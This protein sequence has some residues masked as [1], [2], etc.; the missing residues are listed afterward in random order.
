MS[1]HDR[2]DSEIEQRATSGLLD[3]LI[4]AGLILALVVLCYQVFAPFLTL[5]VWAVILA[6]ALYPLHQYLAGKIGGEARARSDDP[7][8]PRH[9]GD[10]RADRRA[11]ELAGRLGASTDHRRAGEHARDPG[12]ARSCRNVAL[13]WREAIWDLVGGVQR[14]A[15]A[16]SR[17]SSRRSATSRRRRSASSPASAPGCSNSSP[18]SSSPASSWPSVSRAAVE[19]SPSSSASPAP[20]GAPSSPSC[21]RRPY[22]PSHKAS[23]ASPSFRQSSSAFVCCSPACPGR[24]CWR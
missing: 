8:P 10:H 11:D 4:R 6:V 18:P 16:S 15:C 17:A 3:V 5:M 21:P 22:A 14:P 24:A 20:S 23:S 12:S 9:R 7:R 19:V 13:G 2:L 1:S